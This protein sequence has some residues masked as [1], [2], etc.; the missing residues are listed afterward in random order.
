MRVYLVPNTK[1]PQAVQ[2]ACE[3]A[4]VLAEEGAVPLLEKRFLQLAPQ[5]P[6]TT[7]FLSGHSAFQSCDIVVTI[8]GDGTMLHTARHTIKPQKP[9]AGINMGQ[10]GFLTIIEADEQEKVRLLARG[11]YK[12]ENRSVLQAQCLESG[13]FSGLA[14]NDVVLFKQKPEKTIALDIY[15]DDIK[16]SGFRGDGVVFATSTGSTAY[17]LSAGGP[18]VDNRLGGIVVTQ[19]CAHIVHAA[20]MVFA[21]NRVLRAVPPP[22]SDEKIYVSCDGLHSQVL[23]PGQAVVIRQAEITVPMIQ[24][25]D[26]GQ[27][28]SIDKKLKGR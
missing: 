4:A 23:A 7:E 19:I 5:C 8:G 24:F 10:L 28:E 22:G 27:L 13:A 6:P 3:V 9:M 18:V 14:L 20:P 17:S 25:H 15:C 21:A 2:L 1:K 16:V 26:A 11:Q 12:V